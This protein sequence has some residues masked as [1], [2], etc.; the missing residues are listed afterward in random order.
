MPVPHCLRQLY[1]N[2]LKIAARRKKSRRGRTIAIEHGHYSR[3]DEH[4]QCWTGD[5]ADFINPWECLIRIPSLMDACLPTQRSQPSLSGW[6][7]ISVKFEHSLKCDARALL[8]ESS[9]MLQNAAMK[10]KWEERC[11]EQPFRRSNM[12]DSRT[13]LKPKR[14]CSRATIKNINTRHYMCVY[15][16]AE[17]HNKVAQWVMT[18]ICSKRS[19]PSYLP[20]LRYYS[21]YTHTFIIHYTH[22][23]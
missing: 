16:S 12:A 2:K 6:T 4:Q 19:F 18:I 17:Y 11:K 22:Y 20:C 3:A 21:P 10:K 1:G 23:I 13:E 14:H 9:S 5:E 15:N 7:R 8:F